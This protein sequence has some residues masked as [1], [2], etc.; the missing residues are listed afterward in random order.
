MYEKISGYKVRFTL[1]TCCLVVGNILFAIYFQTRGFFLSLDDQNLK[2][3]PSLHK[4]YTSK[5]CFSPAY[6][7]KEKSFPL[8]NTQLGPHFLS[9][10]WWKPTREIADIL[11]RWKMFLSRSLQLPF[12]NLIW[13]LFS[14]AS[15]S[16]MENLWSQQTS[17]K[18]GV[19]LTR[20]CK[21]GFQTNDTLCL[22]SFKN[23]T[24][25]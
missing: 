23:F 3:T 13:F 12:C 16:W 18:K 10:Q 2:S 6:L 24:K 21:P 25:K 11:P 9:L 14:F 22:L 19:V 17:R 4:W 5:N 15:F 1:I 8:L 20:V 7:H